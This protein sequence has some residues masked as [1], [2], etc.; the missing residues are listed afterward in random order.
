[1]T[2]QEVEKGQLELVFHVRVQ[3]VKNAIAKAVSRRPFPLV[4][5]STVGDALMA[6]LVG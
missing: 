4:V 2:A 5:C 6:G 1:M 3:R